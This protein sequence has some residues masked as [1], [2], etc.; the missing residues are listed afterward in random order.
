MSWIGQRDWLRTS[1]VNF[2][3]KTP[4]SLRARLY[5]M[6]GLIQ[7]RGGRLPKR[8]CFRSCKPSQHWYWM[9]CESECTVSRRGF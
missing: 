3:G 6:F 8:D 7:K 5:K 4:R 9:H 1:I 2:I